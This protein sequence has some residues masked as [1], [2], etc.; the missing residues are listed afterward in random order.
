MDDGDPVTQVIYT[1]V[2]SVGELT[3]SVTTCGTTKN[4]S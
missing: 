4:I 1:S 3:Q 2:S